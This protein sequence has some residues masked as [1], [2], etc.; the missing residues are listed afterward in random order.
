MSAQQDVQFISINGNEITGNGAYVGSL[1][2]Y[3]NSTGQGDA[4]SSSGLL[5]AP[6]LSSPGGGMQSQGP[7]VLGIG[8]QRLATG[9]I[10]NHFRAR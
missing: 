8:G 9:G 1:S 10:A 7:R 4:I 2:E 5:Q 3:L 6:L